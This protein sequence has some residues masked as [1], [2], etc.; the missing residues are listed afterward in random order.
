MAHKQEFTLEELNKMNKQELI[1]LAESLHIKT[2]NLS[3]SQIIRYILGQRPSN[4]SEQQVVQESDTLEVFE[5]PSDV[6]E[7]IKFTTS[8]LTLPQTRVLSDSQSI[9]EAQ[10]RYNLELKL[11]EIEME[12]R[13]A[14]REAEAEERRAQVALEE[15]KLKMEFDLRALEIN[16]RS[17][18]PTD[19]QSPILKLMQLVFQTD[20][21]RFSLTEVHLLWLCKEMTNLII[22]KYDENFD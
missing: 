7:D 18:P 15:R 1:Q 16:A 14:T 22:I 2:Q 20:C 13:K 4:T 6:T 21:F 8:M 19:S 9:S 17:R 11:L 12:D 3:K 5:D 10:L